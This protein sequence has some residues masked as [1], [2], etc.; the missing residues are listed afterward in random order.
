M[1]EARLG[2]SRRAREDLL[3]IWDYIA[4]DSPVVADR[5]FDRIEAR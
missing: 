3:A 2:F 5:V 1:K 4:I